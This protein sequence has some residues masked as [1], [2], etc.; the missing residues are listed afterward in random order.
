MTRV[1]IEKSLTQFV[2][3]AGWINKKE[4]AG[5]LG[6]HFQSDLVRRTTKGLPKIG[7]KYSTYDVSERL[8]DMQEVR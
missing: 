1:Q 6:C 4:L 2:N 3:G 5:Y 7:Q 8:F